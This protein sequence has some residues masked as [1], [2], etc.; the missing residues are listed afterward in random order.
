MQVLNDQQRFDEAD[1]LYV[2]AF[3]ADPTNANLLVHRSELFN[4]ILVN[5]Q[6]HRIKE[7]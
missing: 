3:N 7:R 4:F 2:K 1:E 5:V 6:A